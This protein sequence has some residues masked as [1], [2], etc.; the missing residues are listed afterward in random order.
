MG[1]LIF[2]FHSD[3]NP[4]VAQ[5]WNIKTAADRGGFN[6]ISFDKISDMKK[7]NSTYSIRSHNRNCHFPQNDENF[8]TT[9]LFIYKNRISVRI[10]PHSSL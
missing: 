5:I 8:V 7:N 9:K 6:K 3:S 2:L 1:L 4:V 10:S